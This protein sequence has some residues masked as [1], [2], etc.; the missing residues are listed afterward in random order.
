VSKPV[1]FIFIMAS[2]IIVS[3]TLMGILLLGVEKYLS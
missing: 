3:V 1:K 2:S